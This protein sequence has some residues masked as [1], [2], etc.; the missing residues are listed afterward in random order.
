MIRIKELR[1]EMHKSLRDVASELNI[2]YSSLSKYERGDQQ[3][4]YETLIRIANYFNVTTD[5]LIGITN[6]KSSENRSICDQLNLSDEAIQKLKQLPLIVDK[7]N[8]ISLSDILNFIIIQPEFEHLLKSI[9]LY[10]ART[11]ADWCNMKKYL[12]EDNTVPFSQHQ[13][14]EIDKLYIVQQFNNIL[15]H[16]LENEVTTY[17]TINKTKN[18]II[19]SEHKDTTS[20]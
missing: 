10:K 5:Y 13:I 4:S 7:N 18:G 6:S 9:L 2:S 14:K 17:N 20:D 15:S 12:N 19:I 1:T 8:G 16:V 3:P 11:P